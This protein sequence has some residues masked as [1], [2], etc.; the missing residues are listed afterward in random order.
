MSAGIS[1][2]GALPSGDGNGLGAV[3][4]DLVRDPS[5]KH[6]VVAI[7]DT[8]KIVTRPDSG[9]VVPTVRVRRIEVITGEDAAL[10]EKLMRRALDKRTG[11]QPLA[12]EDDDLEDDLA[13]AFGTGDAGAF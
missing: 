10:A 12:G 2:S 4:A 13:A 7:I 9:E 8:A 6:P 3:I 11:G 5:R 1:M